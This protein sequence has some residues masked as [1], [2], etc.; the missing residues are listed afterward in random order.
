MPSYP[1]PH[2]V[3]LGSG[4]SSQESQVLDGSPKTQTPLA[5]ISTDCFP[6]HES[7]LYEPF[8]PK[9][10]PPSILSPVSN[11][12]LEFLNLECHSRQPLS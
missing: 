8:C 10:H 5:W 4:S 9:L 2:S 7:G 6:D 11:L 3:A 12:D 1:L